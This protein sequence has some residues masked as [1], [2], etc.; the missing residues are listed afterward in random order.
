[1]SVGNRNRGSKAGLLLSVV[2]VMKRIAGQ[3]I[4]H[5]TVISFKIV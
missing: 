4:Y 3:E 2:L 1:M 5:G